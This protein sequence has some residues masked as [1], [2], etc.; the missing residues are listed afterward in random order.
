[1]NMVSDMKTTNEGHLENILA[2]FIR[3]CLPEKVECEHDL[4]G[5]K[6]PAV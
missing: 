6:E 1:M 4:R 5:L 3:E 2:K